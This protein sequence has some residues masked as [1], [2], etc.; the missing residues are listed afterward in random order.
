VILNIITYC[1]RHCDNFH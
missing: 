1:A